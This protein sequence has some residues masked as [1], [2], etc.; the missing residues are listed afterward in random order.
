MR[1][2][3]INS[4]IVCSGPDDMVALMTPEMAATDITLGR[5]TTVISNMHAAR[6]DVGTKG[7]LV[8]DDPK[9]ELYQRVLRCMGRLAWTR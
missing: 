7:R 2:P 5:K 8:D 1:L 3:L 9:E 6:M 4:S